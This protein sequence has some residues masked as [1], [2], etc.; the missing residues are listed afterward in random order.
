MGMGLAVDPFICMEAVAFS[1]KAFILS[2][3]QLLIP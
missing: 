1:Y 2:V 3:K